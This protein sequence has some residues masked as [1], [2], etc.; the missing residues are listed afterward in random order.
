VT[1][2]CARLYDYRNGKLLPTRNQKSTAM[3]KS[4]ILFTVAAGL[5]NFVPMKANPILVNEKIGI[6]ISSDENIEKA[7]DLSDKAWWIILL[8]ADNKDSLHVAIDLCSQAIDLNPDLADAY[9]NRADAKCD[10]ENYSEALT[11]FNIVIDKRGE[12]RDFQYRGECKF[13]LNDNDGALTDFQTAESKGYCE[14]DVRKLIAD[15]D[16]NQLGIAFYNAEQYD[17]AVK[18]FTISIDAEK[19]KNNLFNRAN[20]EYMAGNHSDALVDWKASGKLGNKDGR[21][22][23]RK[24]RKAN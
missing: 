15:G 22:S 1:F 7:K 5:I 17:K 10:L 8:N 13:K 14:N 12:A 2:P 11:D 23:Y 18:A 21:K 19:T 9:F 20:S 6:T 3:K 16:A 24:Y 4:I